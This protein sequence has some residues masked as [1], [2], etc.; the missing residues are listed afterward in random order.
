MQL[1][2]DYNPVT[3]QP[4]V[5]LAFNIKNPTRKILPAF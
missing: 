2:P 4:N 5:G 1:K 3:K